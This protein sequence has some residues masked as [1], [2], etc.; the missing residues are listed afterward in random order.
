MAVKRHKGY[1]TIKLLIEGNQLKQFRDM[2]EHIPKTTVNRDLGI[3]YKRFSEI[4][5]DIKGFKLG[6]LYTLAHLIGV[7]EKAVVDLAH[8]QYLAD[9]VKKGAKKK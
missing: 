7:D 6:E 1:H 2:F 8:T 5:K 4:S 9:K 3:N